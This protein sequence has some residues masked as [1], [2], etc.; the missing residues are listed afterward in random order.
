M[1]ALVAA[2]SALVANDIKRV[3]AFSTVSQ[4]GYMMLALGVGSTH[5][6]MFHLTTHAFFKALLF[7]GSGSVIHAVHTNDIWKMGGLSKKLPV[8]FVTFGCG[9]LAIIGFPGFAGFFSKEG[10][11]AA[12][13]AGHHP[14]LFALA[15]FTAFLTAFYMCRV[16][17]VTFL[18][19]PRDPHLFAHA[20]EGGPSMGLP[21]S[22]LAVLSVAAG[23][24]LTYVWPFDHWVPSPGEEHHGWLVPGVSLGALVAGAGLAWT[25][26]RNRNPDPARLAQEWPKVYNFLGRRYLDEIYLELIERVVY[27]PARALSRF[28]YDILDQGIVDGFG[29]VAERVARFKRWFDDTVVDGILVNGAGRLSQTLGAGARRL[30]TGYAQ[31]YLLAVAFGLSLLILWA[32]RV[33]G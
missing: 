32:V 24:F 27:R 9:T 28:D 29:W 22:L 7:L 13:L 4:L 23:F 18:G 26:Y 25:M 6:A 2:S 1:T 10:I 11:L 14:V 30:Q 5:A 16:F 33:F 15:G 3:L 12:A 20:H 8:T 19:D 21:L 31:F 17:F